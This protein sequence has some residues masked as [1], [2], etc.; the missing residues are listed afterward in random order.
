MSWT[1]TDNFS[2]GNVN[3]TATIKVDINGDKKPNK[4]YN[5][6]KPTE[7]KTPD[8]FTFT[9]RANGQV[10]VPANDAVAQKYLQS[11]K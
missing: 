5:P 9:V 11:R 8:Q 6:D 2:A 4:A 3:S 10:T 1:V 7:V